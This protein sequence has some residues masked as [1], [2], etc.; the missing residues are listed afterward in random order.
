MSRKKASEE[1]G[2][3]GVR[4]G[5]T[6]ATSHIHQSATAVHSGTQNVS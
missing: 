2:K 5:S 1:R 3:T 6:I 4:G